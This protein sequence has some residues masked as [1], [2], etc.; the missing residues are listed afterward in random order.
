MSRQPLPPNKRG[1]FFQ[2]VPKKPVEHIV[3]MVLGDDRVS[4]AFREKLAEN[5]GSPCPIA[6]VFTTPGKQHIKPDENGVCGQTPGGSDLIHSASHHVS[7]TVTSP[8]GKHQKDV[9]LH[10]LR[11]KQDYKPKTP[12]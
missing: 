6:S 11:R 8:G 3:P 12:S 10:C 7:V 1:D 2:L 4:D 5:T 9:Q